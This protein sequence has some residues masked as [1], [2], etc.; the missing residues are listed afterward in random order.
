VAD[1]KVAQTYFPTKVGAK[2]E[3]EYDGKKETEEVTAVK[4]ENDSFIVTVHRVDGFGS[5][6]K[7][8]LKVAKDGLFRLTG[9]PAVEHPPMWLLKLPHKAGARWETWTGAQG[10]GDSEV[11]AFGPEKVKVPAGTFEAIRTETIYPQTAPEDIVGKFWYAPGVGLVKQTYGK[12]VR[13]LK[14]FSPGKD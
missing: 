6:S 2:W 8:E 13:V 9:G 10:H 14:S 7:T 4:K 5:K 11:K 3:Y 1:E 12:Y